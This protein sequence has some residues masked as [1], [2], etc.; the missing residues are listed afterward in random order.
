MRK[1]ALLISALAFTS[2]FGGLV[3]SNASHCGT[4]ARTAHDGFGS[5]ETSQG[6]VKCGRTGATEIGTGGSGQTSVGYLIVDPSKGAQACAEDG[7]DGIPISG[8]ITAYK[9]SGNKVTVAADGGDQHNAAF[10]G[11]SGWDRVDAD[12]DNQKVCAYRG[13]QGTYWAS[14]GAPGTVGTATGEFS[15]CTP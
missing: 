13:S 4:T 6:N 15:V 8:R 7:Q 12:A 10:G 5:C 11:A 1:S 14:G 9:H 3:A 2:V